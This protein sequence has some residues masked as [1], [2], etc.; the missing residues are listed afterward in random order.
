MRLTSSRG[1]PRRIV[2]FGNSGS[3]KSTLAT[4]LA[5]A[6]GVVHLDLDSLAWMDSDPPQ[7]KPLAEAGME[8]TDFI[9]G[10]GGWIIEGCYADLLD[11]VSAEADGLVWLDLPVALCIDNARHRP[12]EPHKYESPAAQNANLAMLIEWIGQ[13]ESRDDTFSR[14]AHR[15]LCERFGGAKWI[16][17]DNSASARLVCQLLT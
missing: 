12:W 5:D 9:R 2:I 7:R 1:P 6:L 16:I 10:T 13:Y 14:V 11:I 15:A 3:G 4:A 8:L 17:T